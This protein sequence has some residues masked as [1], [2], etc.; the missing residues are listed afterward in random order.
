MH[1]TRSRP[2]LVVS[3]DGHGVV[4]HAGSRL[5]ADLADATSLTSAFSGALR[6][7]RPRGTGHD[8]GRVAMDLTVMLADG[9]EAIRD[10]AVLRNQRDVFGPVASTPTA[11]RVLAGIDT[12]ALSTVRAARTQAREVAWLQAAETRD[13]IPPARAGGR[14]LPSLVLDIDAIL[15]T[16]HSEK[17]QAAATYKRGFG[18]HPLLCFLDNTGE[19][20]AG[21]LRPGNAGANT[22]ADHITLLEQ[23]L[24]QIPDAHRYGTPILV[25]ADSAGGAKAF[26]THLRALRQRGI[27]TTFSVGHAVTAD[28]R[29][30]IRALP[31]QLW[32]PALEQDGSLRAGAEVARRRPPVPADQERDDR[33]QHDQESP[34]PRLHEST[35]HPE[36]I[37]LGVDAH[38][39]VHVAAV[40]TCTGVM[41]GT[42]SFPTTR[43]G[44]R[45]LLSWAQ[46]FG[47][48]QW[49][50]VECTGSY[51][52]ALTCYLRDEGI[53]VTE[54][55]QPDKALR[56]RRGKS[57]A[58]D[59]GAAA[60]AV[61]SGRATATAKSA[62]KASA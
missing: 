48:L 33:A 18:Y 54:V 58:I 49:A 61:L 60:H 13:G 30:A 53:A 45:Q 62:D 14:Q 35:R 28:F 51:G 25:R 47:R 12:A 59:A 5:L 1:P 36:E 34:S 38:K 46:A 32:H 26:L 4:S 56:R 31:E 41:L 22:A 24:A 27:R 2:K 55:N 17:E 3:A 52:A 37:V 6:R 42:R 40:I 19:A 16:C 7:P 50:G 11:W 15:V 21:L 39:D 10:L 57:D 43:E 23:A 29:R 20:L 44:C 9:G 8:P